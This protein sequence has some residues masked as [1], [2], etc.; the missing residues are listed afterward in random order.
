MRGAPASRLFGSFD[1]LNMNGK[2]IGAKIRCLI[3]TMRAFS[4]LFY[5]S[6][7]SFSI[8]S[9]TEVVL[10]AHNN[11][12]VGGTRDGK[13][14]K[15]TE[16]PANFGK[17][18]KFRTIE[19]FLAGQRSDVYG[20]L[21]ELGCAANL[22]YFGKTSDVPA[23]VF[24]DRTLRPTLAI[25]ANANWNPVPRLVKKLNPAGYQKIALDFLRTKGIRAKSVKIERVVSVD[26]DGDGTQEIFLEATNYKNRKGEIRTLPR[27]GNFSFVLMRKTVGAKTKNYLIEGEFHPRKPVDPD[28]VSEFDLSEFADLNGDGKMEVIL[29]GLF[30][31]GGESTEVYEFTG[32]GLEEVL[33]IECGD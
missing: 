17:P 19:S 33:S 21:G 30:S 26:L 31:Y 6:V 1:G 16:V 12:L 4:L 14:L 2:L 10:I 27:A 32:S 28:Y 25:G 29:K 23:D 22:Y 7:L 9:Q 24:S 18:E 13:W 15:D 20:T 3:I 8:Y 5:V 11:Y